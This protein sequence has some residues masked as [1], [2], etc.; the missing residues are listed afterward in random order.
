MP[1][2]CLATNIFL[3]YIYKKFDISPILKAVI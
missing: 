3:I 2:V 1:G